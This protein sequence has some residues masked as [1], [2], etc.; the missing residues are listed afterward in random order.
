MRV[1]LSLVGQQPSAVAVAVATL[2]EHRQALDRLLLL[3]TSGARGTLAQA[4]RLRDWAADLGIK[5]DVVP[6][7]DSSQ[8]VAVMRE[9][10]REPPRAD[11]LYLADAGLKVSV[12]ALARELPP[13]ATVGHADAHWLHLKGPRPAER[14][15]LASLGL[16]ALLRLY[17]L[18]FVHRAPDAAVLARLGLSGSPEG[19]YDL[20]L[21]SD[22]TV[23]FDLAFES[24]G[25]LF[26]VG[27]AEGDNK[28]TA[29]RNL[30]GA[31][32][33]LKG[34]RPRL[35]VLSGDRFV[36]WRVDAGQ[37]TSIGAEKVRTGDSPLKAKLLEAFGEKPRVEALLTRRLSA[38]RPPHTLDR[39][40][41]KG[42]GGQRRETLIVVLGSDPSATLVSLATHSPARAWI[43]YDRESKKIVEALPRFLECV[44]RMRVGSALLVPT[45]LSGTGLGDRLLPL[46]VPGDDAIID[47][48]PGSKPQA[49][50]LARLPSTA[51]RLWSQDNRAGLARCL[52]DEQL[53]RPLSAPDVLVWAT[54]NGGRLEGRPGPSK[55]TPAHRRFLNT[56]ARFLGHWV[57]GCGRN[58]RLETVPLVPRTCAHGSLAVE[59]LDPGRRMA[60]NV[61]VMWGGQSAAGPLDPDN[62]HYFEDLVAAALLDAGCEDVLVEVAF[63]WSDD[64]ARDA[65]A[66][67]GRAGRAARANVGRVFH[68]QIDVVA[69]LGHRFL[70]VSCKAGESDSKDPDAAMGEIRSVAPRATGRLGLPVLAVTRAEEDR[71]RQTL[72]ARSGA[73]LLDLT[74]LRDPNVLR[75]TLLEALRNRS[76]TIDV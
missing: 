61:H 42:K 64:L 56:L 53:T 18:G 21:R 3:P 4:E 2:R 50:A 9:L 47:I 37:L 1:A 15:P 20:R 62:G 39:E 48:T 5:P 31:A 46:V 51:G 63:Q 72:S 38:P 54:A 65:R 45:D 59:P 22:R 70:G 71:R 36:R 10:L 14:M 32:S 75:E 52:Q 49:I 40:E 30:E 12:V 24:R 26:A 29:E 8:A 68:T 11:V 34:L 6:V 33:A 66:A 67:T 74:V 27:V 43:C 58:Q 13:D 76:T 17:D 69:R 23:H 35:G 41:V 28:T 16:D 57:S 19:M 60:A 73:L 44:E 7:A 25:Q 55:W